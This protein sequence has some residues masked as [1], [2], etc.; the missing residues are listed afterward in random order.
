MKRFFLLLYLLT[1]YVTGAEILQWVQEPTM[2]FD[3]KESQWKISFAVNKQTDVEIS[4]VDATTNVVVRHLVAGQLGK[5][6]LPPLQS[7]N[8]SQNLIW[9]G[10]D[11]FGEKV[12][13]ASKCVLRVRAGM[14][15][16]LKT[17]VGGDP[18]A[19]YSKEIGQG[20]HAHW[21]ITGLEVKSDGMV[22]VMGNGNNLGPPTIRQYDGNGEF[23]KTVFPFAANKPIENMLGWGLYIKEDGTYAPKYNDDLS[24]PALTNTLISRTRAGCANLLPTQSP[25]A[26]QLHFG[27]QVMTIGTDGTLKVYQAKPLVAKPQMEQGKILGPIYKT[28]SVDKKSFY[29]SGVFSRESKDGNVDKSTFWRD[30]QVWKVEEATGNAEIFFSIPENEVILTMKER[31]ASGIGHT[32]VNPYAA[33]HGV[34]VDKDD[35]VFIC[36]RQYK[37]I[38][39][40][41]KSAKEIKTIPIENLDAIVVHP[42]SKAIYVT[43]RNGNYHKKGELKL[44][45]FNDWSQD[46]TPS[47]TVPLCIAG[48]YPQNSYLGIVETKDGINIWVGFTDLPIRVYRDM[49]SALILVKDFYEANQN[50]VLD[51]QHMMVDQKT[52]DVY[53]SDG[54]GHCFKINDWAN[55]QFIR[56]MV[57]ER[58]PLK[59]LSLGIDFKNR[60]IYGHADR[61]AVMRYK[62]D[63]EYYSLDSLGEDKTQGLSPLITNDWRIGLGFGDRGIAAAPNG[64]FATINGFGTGPDYSGYLNYF[65]E[66][67]GKV[68]WPSLFFEKFGKGRMGGVRF[69]YQGNLYVGKSG[70]IPVDIPKGYEK[71]DNFQRTTGRIYK[72]S[73]TKVVGKD[74]LFS[75][76]PTAP[77]K[78][79]DINYG[80]ISPGFSRTPR[81]GVDGFGRIYYPTTLTNQV[82]VIDNNGNNILTFGTYGNRDS[83]GGLPGDLVPTNDIPLA[84]PNSVDATDDFIYV[85]DFVNIRILRIEKK[86]ELNHV[87]KK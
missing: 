15:V 50:K 53:I 16:K 19:Y 35:N 79:Y 55:P 20:D 12:Q 28:Y 37:I 46:A 39:I 83:L 64:S 59:A 7:D 21:R 58:T 67:E 48:V 22:Y 75:E 65:S 42:K 86:F 30:G 69:D 27:L 84:Y 1:T 54:W 77:A 29:L 71:D 74:N 5:N 51:M 10:K 25:D 3:E 82:S 57:D 70:Q 6:A 44:L 34:A 40:L 61:K 68:P 43:T 49:G 26:L 38:R 23:I 73:T 60:R 8:L 41:D 2:V 14:S 45:K 63:G 13:N 76:E 80:A 32:S 72:F 18:Y 33:F 9:D 11:D 17:I 85:S 31:S 52:D 62:M 36:D 47:V 56:C 66:V 4:I 87:T 24:S 78:V 81:F